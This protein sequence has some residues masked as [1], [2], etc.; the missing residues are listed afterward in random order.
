M[1]STT[2]VDPSAPAT[3]DYDNWL[4]NER[5]EI[6]ARM[7]NAQIS[8]WAYGI[9]FDRKNNVPRPSMQAGI[10]AWA[11]KIRNSLREAA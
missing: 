10:A 11:L 9:A 4:V 2:K 3:H 1:T 7:T 5:D 8:A 6:T